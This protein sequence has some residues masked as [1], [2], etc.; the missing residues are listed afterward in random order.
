MFVTNKVKYHCGCFTYIKFLLE[1]N[2]FI[3]TDACRKNI[4]CE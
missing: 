4:S 2:P 1:Q 3:H